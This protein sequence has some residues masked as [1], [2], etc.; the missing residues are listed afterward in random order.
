M[1]RI[2]AAFG[3]FA[4][5]DIE[6]ARE[7]YGH[8]L[9]LVVKG[10]GPGSGGP[11]WLTAGDGPAVFVYPKPDHEPAGFTV[12]HLAVE[13]IELAIDQ[14]G[15]RGIA[16]QQLEGVPQDE[17]GIFRGEGHSI[18]WFTDPAGNSLSVA[19]LSTMP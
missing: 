12:M 1:D 14:L 19:T 6:A 18:A 7:F 2:K 17:R 16:M 4:V 3:S 10:A 8:T 15:A 5:D 9:G 11:F 13:D